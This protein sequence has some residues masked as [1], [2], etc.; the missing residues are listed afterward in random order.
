MI[1]GG[2]GATSAG[3][4]GGGSYRGRNG[5]ILTLTPS[6]LIILMG[7]EQLDTIYDLQEEPRC[8][9]SAANDLLTG[10][11][12]CRGLSGGAGADASG[13]SISEACCWVVVLRL[14]LATI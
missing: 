11:I 12:G 3:G 5:D 8:S 6:G 2:G 13:T 10:G 4:A 9:G 1:H 14:V 7:G